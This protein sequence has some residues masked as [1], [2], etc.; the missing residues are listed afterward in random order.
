MSHILL[1]EPDRILA[2]TYAQALTNAGHTVSPCSG[3]QIA[4]MSAD[5]QKPDLVI[6]EIQLIEHSGIEFLYEF[7]SYSDWRDI[8]VIVH[9]FVPSSEFI[10]NKNIMQNQLGVIYYL[11]KHHTRLKDLLAKVNST[12]LVK[13]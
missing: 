8:P 4:I 12:L 5:Q 10:S 3:A 7:R 2:E 6:L 11:E 13:S 9:S 1:I